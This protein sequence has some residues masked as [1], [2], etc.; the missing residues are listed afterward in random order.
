VVADGGAGN[1]RRRGRPG[2]AP[3]TAEAVRL[4]AQLLALQAADFIGDQKEI[5]GFWWV[6]E[7][8]RNPY[9]DR[10]AL[11]GA[12]LALLDWRGAAGARERRALARCRAPALE[13]YAVPM[14]A[15]SAY[16]IMPF[17]CFWGRP[18]GDLPAAGGRPD[19]R[20]FMPARKQFWWLGM[21][22]H[23]ECYA[24]LLA[25]A[26]RCST[27]ARIATWRTGNWNGDGAN[28]FGACLMTGRAC[29]IRTRTRV[30]WG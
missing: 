14:A 22:S 28:P 30:S 23:L 24:L 19:Y 18:E 13:E 25:E 3:Y 5:R 27:A 17:G 6:S 7:R 10:R 2:N 29:A 15:H 20:Y 26:A 21:T 1:A 11:G 8:D 12:R 9:T 4:G 16:A